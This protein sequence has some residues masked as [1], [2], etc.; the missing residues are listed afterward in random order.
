M[1]KIKVLFGLTEETEISSC[2]ERYLK[3]RKNLRKTL[4]ECMIVKAFAEFKPKNVSKV[5]EG[6][7]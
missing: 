6:S 5:C 1:I 4:Y 2:K 3:A 7:W